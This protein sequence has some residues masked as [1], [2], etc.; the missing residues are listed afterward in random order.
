VEVCAH[1]CAPF[2]DRTEVRLSKLLQLHNGY[3]SQVLSTIGKLNHQL[4]LSPDEFEYAKH[5]C[6]SWILS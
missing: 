1:D 2:N 3:I 4:S 6:P 5:M